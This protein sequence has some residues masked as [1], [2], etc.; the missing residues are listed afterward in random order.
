MFIC[1]RTKHGSANFNFLFRETNSVNF[2]FALFAVIL[3]LFHHLLKLVHF[4]N[5]SRYQNLL[6]PV[7]SFLDS[8][9]TNNVKK[10][11]LAQLMKKVYNHY[12]L[13][14]FFTV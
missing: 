11:A 7:R 5:M 1:V 4:N 13:G 6:S 3:F 9:S 10:T 14:R 2:D 8:N 12:S